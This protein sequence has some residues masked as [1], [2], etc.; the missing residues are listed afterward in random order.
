MPKA[1][2]ARRYTDEFKKDAVALLRSYR[3]A[4]KGGG[5]AVRRIGHLAVGLGP[6]NG[7]ER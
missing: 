1:A 6:G 3:P 4:T 7:S 2:S 5:Q